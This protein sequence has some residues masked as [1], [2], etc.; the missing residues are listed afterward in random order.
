[1]RPLLNNSSLYRGEK[2]TKRSLFFTQ[3]TSSNT[4]KTS[5]KWYTKW[6]TN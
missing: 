2:A 4:Q 6:Y 5:K 3:T 1:H